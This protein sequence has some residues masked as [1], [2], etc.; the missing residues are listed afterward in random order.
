[1]VGY[2]RTFIYLKGVGKLGFQTSN[3]VES[4]EAKVFSRLDPRKEGHSIGHT[5]GRMVIHLGVPREDMI[6][7]LGVP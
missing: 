4:I 6:I 1:M 5:P 7:P 2:W 3:V